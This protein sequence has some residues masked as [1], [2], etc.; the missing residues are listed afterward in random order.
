MGLITSKPR[1]AGSRVY[2]DY[3]PAVLETI[4]LV[5]QAQR[6]GLSLKEIGPLLKT[7]ASAPLSAGTYHCIS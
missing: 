6:L 5:R 7:H 2:R 4:E 3:D 1:Q